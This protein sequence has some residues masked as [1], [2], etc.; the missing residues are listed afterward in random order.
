M[1]KSIIIM[2]ACALIA[3]PAAGQ[4][5]GEKTGINEVLGITPSTKDFVKEAA[6]SDMFEMDFSALAQQE[7]TDEATKSLAK[8]MVTDLEKT[9]KEL[10]EA[11][12]SNPST[13]IP[14]ELDSSHK[15]KLEK[16]KD[17]KGSNF[18]KTYLDQQVS[19]H[20]D[21]V[22]LFERYG[23]GGDNPTLKAWAEKTLP[24]LKQHLELAQSLDKKAAS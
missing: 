13:P 23:K 5:I 15:S 7:A 18:T 10:T 19:A 22:S 11:V 17:L 3:G 6:T 9:T 14:T 16:L 1:K 8:Q 21:A 24:T 12:G 4:S 20:K 2:A